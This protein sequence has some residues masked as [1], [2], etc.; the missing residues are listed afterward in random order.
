MVTLATPNAATT[1]FTAPGTGSLSFQLRV[2]DSDGKMGTDV[3]AVRIN[4][5]PTLAA[6]PAGPVVPAGSVVTFMVTGSDADGD[7]LTFVATAPTTVPL[8]ALQP[9]GQFIWNTAGVPAG[10]YQLTYFATDGLSQSATQTVFIALTPSNASGGGGGGA[11]PWSQLLLL[12]A[13]LLAP[14]LR[15][16]E[17]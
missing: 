1:T 5:T 6:A 12:G 14:S 8:A 3:V 13:L 9:G 15:P 17:R 2:T 7:A 16:R 10:T 11:L 4:N